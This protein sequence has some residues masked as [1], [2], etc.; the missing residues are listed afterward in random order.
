MIEN[1]EGSIGEHGQ[2]GT[3]GTSGCVGPT[4][5]KDEH[6]DTLTQQGNMRQQIVDSSLIAQYCDKNGLG[7]PS[8]ITLLSLL[9]EKGRIYG[10]VFSNSATIF[11]VE[12]GIVTNHFGYVQR[13]TLVAQS[14]QNTVEEYFEKLCYPK[15]D[16]CQLVYSVPLGDVYR[17]TFK[18]AGLGMY[19]NISGDKLGT[20]RHPCYAI[21][22]D[23]V[24]SGYP[25]DFWTDADKYR[26]VLKQHLGMLQMEAHEKE[27]RTPSAPATESK[28]E[29]APRTVNPDTIEAIVGRYEGLVE[30]LTRELEGVKKDYGR[31]REKRDG[32][33]KIAQSKL[34]LIERALNGTL[35][36]NPDTI[37]GE[38]PDP[39]EC[40]TEQGNIDFLADDGAASQVGEHG[41]SIEYPISIN[42]KSSGGINHYS[43]ME[44]NKITG[45][46]Y[47]QSHEKKISGEWLD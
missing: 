35:K 27:K 24:V 43:Q 4:D 28:K 7:I 23:G 6:S 21:V 18:P 25:E 20:H 29:E 3:A 15:I 32:A 30:S 5:Q 42:E 10:V 2:V 47:G 38:N 31:E 44:F 11:V 34:D 26:L 1:I 39:V 45:V 37:P 36:Q 46:N 33:L 41:V 14:P 40:M 17:V 8:S 22:K 19:G 9:H 16:E 12:Y 13:Q